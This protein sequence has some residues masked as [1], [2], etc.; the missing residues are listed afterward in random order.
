MPPPSRHDLRPNPA[1]LMSHPEWGKRYRQWVAEFQKHAPLEYRLFL[2]AATLFAIAFTLY[3]LPKVGSLASGL[4]FALALLGWVWLLFRLHLYTMLLLQPLRQHGGNFWPATR[5]M[6]NLA[7]RTSYLPKLSVNGNLGIQTLAFSALALNSLGI[8][9]DW[10]SFP[11][12][13]EIVV[14]VIL[15]T[16]MSLVASLVYTFRPPGILFLAGSSTENFLRYFEIRM[17]LWIPRVVFLLA[18]DDASVALSVR[19]TARYDLFRCNDDESW[20]ESV[21]ALALLSHSIVLVPHPWTP[22]L[23]QELEDML[24]RN[25]AGRLIILDGPSAM[26]S[27]LRHRLVSQGALIETP[28]NALPVLRQRSRTR[29]R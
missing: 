19:N 3:R 27:A 28:A 14:L 2:P 12:S 22:N 11:V 5:I 24:A 21:R 25:L 13:N 20:I 1:S 10:F 18:A 16:L 15:H 23:T 7:S 8:L 6:Q 26:P 17:T 29:L 4:F 9:K